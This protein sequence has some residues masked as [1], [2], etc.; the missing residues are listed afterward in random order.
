MKSLEEVLSRSEK[1]IPLPCSWDIENYMDYLQ[2]TESELTEDDI[3]RF[4]K[5]GWLCGTAFRIPHSSLGMCPHLVLNEMLKSH[6]IKYLVKAI[7]DTFGPVYQTHV[8]KN[9][10]NDGDRA[11]IVILKDIYVNNSAE[12]N[13]L[14]DKHMWFCT[15]TRTYDDQYVNMCLE[16][17]LAENVTDYVKKECS[18]HI[19]HIAHNR[20]A[21]SI[22]RS[23]I[24]PRG[25]KNSSNLYRA[26]RFYPNRVYCIAAPDDEDAKL[27]IAK[28]KDDKGYS[29]NE[30][31]IYKIDI[32]GYG[33]NLQF[34]RDPQTSTTGQAVFTYAMFPPKMIR[35]VQFSDI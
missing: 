32:S 31:V 20:D 14:I 2:I 3:S 8:V 1:C 12:L 18:N 17:I 25:E 35:K 28:I 15:E 33:G 10:N 9:V 24:R 16:K 21:R 7:R 27:A 23:G 11:W 5:S 34:Y 29:W 13:A 22:D 6:D 4:M 30:L 26:S 19:Y